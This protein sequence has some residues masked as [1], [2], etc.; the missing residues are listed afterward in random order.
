MKISENVKKVLT[1]LAVV[2]AIALLVWFAG[3]V[4]IRLVLYVFGLVS[5]FVFGYITARLINPIADRLRHWL[6][7]PR[8][9]SAVLVIVATLVVVFGGVGLLGYK[10]FDEIRNLYFNWEEIFV[11]IRINWYNFSS[12]LGEMY[13][14]MPGFVKTVIDQA[15]NGMYKQ[16]IEFTS[17]I[18]V[19]DFAQ[20]AAKK[21]PSGLIWTVM[22]ILSLYFMVTQKEK[23]SLFVNK[24]LGEKGTAKV[25]EI[26]N[27]CKKY[28]GGYV[29]A[30]L[31]L[32]VIIFFVMLTVLSL[33][34][35]PFALLVAAITA[36]LDA[37]PFFGSGI[38]LWPMAAVYLIDGQTT[39]GIVYI[40][41]YIAAVMIR[42]FV[43]PKLVSDK[44]GLNPLITLVFMYVGYRLWGIVGLITGPLLLMLIISLYKVGLFNRPIAILKQLMNFIIREAKL[45]EEHLNRITK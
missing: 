18:P 15:I 42:R 25:T 16:C 19:V 27:H 40:G 31:I 28:L 33:A 20:V 14:G 43:E 9:I 2:V 11:S 3:P 22:F 38:I 17:D 39:L 36:F 21:L 10:L 23:V 29:K 26:K 32:M 35:A 44:I 6:K 7:I 37:L 30:Q 24:M 41:I 1:V 45:L 4:F 8:G 12:R 5:P 13:I 34:N